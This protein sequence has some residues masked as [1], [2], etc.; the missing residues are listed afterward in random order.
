M[1]TYVVS[2]LHGQYEAFEAGLKKIEFNDKD[3]LYVIGDAI[4]RGSGG[5]KIL[6]HVKQEKNMDL[7]IGNHEFMMLNA[8][9]PNGKPECN[10][11]NDVLWLYYNGGNA[12]FAEYKKLHGQTRKS[13]LLWLNRRYLIK[14]LKVNGKK[15]CLTHSYYAEECENKQYF[16]LSYRD[17]WHIVWKSQFRH[18]AE[19]RGFDIYKDYD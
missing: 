19:T 12:T 11:Q 9:D 2:D 16:E 10:G 18:D 5:I 4:D 14:T 8:V 3:E 7:I 1:S 6:Q 17:V 15:F 13:L